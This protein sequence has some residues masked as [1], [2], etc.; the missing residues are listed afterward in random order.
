M[1]AVARTQP[2]VRARHFARVSKRTARR[3]SGVVTRASSTDETYVLFVTDEKSGEFV[4]AETAGVAPPEVNTSAT[5][6]EPAP[7]KTATPPKQAA[8]EDNAAEA[9]AWIDASKNKD[10]STAVNPAA[11]SKEVLDTLGNSQ[12][13][14]KAVVNQFSVMDKELGRNPAGPN[15][16]G[17]ARDNLADPDREKAARFKQFTIMDRLTGRNPALKNVKDLGASDAE[18]AAIEKQFGGKK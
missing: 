3:A 16:S 15:A 18:K 14:K 1:F 17:A 7:A 6:A 12:T 13:E 5:D 8:A 9:Q 11:K 10:K 4:R 2:T